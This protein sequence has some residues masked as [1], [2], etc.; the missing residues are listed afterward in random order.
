MCVELDV[1]HTRDGPSEIEE[2]IGSPHL[3]SKFFAN[4]SADLKK[5]KK[6]VNLHI[7]AK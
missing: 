1:T 4:F 7:P 6:V 2:G 5:E 3:L